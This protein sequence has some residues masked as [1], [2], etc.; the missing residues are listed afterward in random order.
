MEQRHL[1]R[2]RGALATAREHSSG[3]M[4]EQ[5]GSIADGILEEDTGERT[6]EH[7]G[8]KI[9][10]VAEVRDKLG[11]LEEKA[12]STAVSTHIAEARDHLREYMQ[13]HPQGGG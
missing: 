4:Q 8:P 11:G 13:T 7:P 12:E 5:L 3:T 9:D 1:K 2:A 6:Q 10:R